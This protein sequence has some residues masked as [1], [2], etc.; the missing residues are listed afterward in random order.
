MS[1]RLQF[2]N[3]SILSDC[4]EVGTLRVPTSASSS[5]SVTLDNNDGLA[6]GD[7]VLFEEV[8]TSRAEIAKINASVTAGTVIQVDTLKFPHNVGVKVYRLAYNQVKFYRADTLTGSKT[9]LGS[10]VNID[11]DDEFTEYIDSV[12]STGYAFFALY[13]STTTAESDPSSGFPYSLLPLSAKSKIREFV[14]KFYKKVLDD[15]TFSFLC[16]SAEDEIYAIRLWR[17]REKSASFSTVI[18]TQKYTFSSLSI[19]DFGTLIY[20]SFDSLYP[21]Q[22]ITIKEHKALNEG[23]M[24]GSSIPQF[25]FLFGDAL[26]LTPTPSSVGTVELLYY[27]NSA[28]FTEETT[29]SP[30]D[31]P[32]AIAFR[33]LQDLWAMDDIKKSEYWE[34]RYL[35]IISVMKS[36]EREQVSR[37]A[38][39]TDSRLTKRRI[40]NSIEYPQITV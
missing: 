9:L 33:I 21:L 28:G 18:G 10:A 26:Y 15:D 32:Q 34:Q 38:P 5:V 7:Y 1:K 20:A 22:S 2:D 37:F 8:G 35:Q 30:V 4:L 6:N 23:S 27:A 40:N 17:F 36:K 14:R 11:V 31:M 3:S 16:D 19:T 39:L 24:N 29:E 12:N 25:I 13:N